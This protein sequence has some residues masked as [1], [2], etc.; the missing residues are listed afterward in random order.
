[1]KKF[2]Q[3]INYPNVILIAIILF[4]FRLI[5]LIIYYVFKVNQ[6]KCPKCNTWFKKGEPVKEDLLGTEMVRSRKKDTEYIRIDGGEKHKIE[7]EYYVNE[8]QSN[9]RSYYNCTK[10]KQL[11]YVDHH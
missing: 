6:I 10:C 8:T 7:H 3:I 11:V 2:F 5:R 4:P 1:M 9:Y